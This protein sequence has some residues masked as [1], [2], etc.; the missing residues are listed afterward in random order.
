MTIVD[1]GEQF[2]SGIKNPKQ[3]NKQ[4]HTRCRALSSGTV[5]TYLDES[6]LPWLGFEHQ[7]FHM[8]GD[9]SNQLRHR[10]GCNNVNKWIIFVENIF[11]YQEIRIVFLDRNT[12]TFV[13]LEIKQQLT[14]FLP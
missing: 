13:D 7:T 10:L 4:K 3:T 6:S 14:L 12:L 9:S 11:S 2:S 5:T 8:R 1:M